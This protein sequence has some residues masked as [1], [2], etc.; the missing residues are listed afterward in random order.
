MER[1]T[2]GTV[3]DPVF[4]RPSQTTTSEMSRVELGP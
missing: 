1:E 4:D 2:R 3:T